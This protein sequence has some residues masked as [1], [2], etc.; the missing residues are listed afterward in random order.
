MSF[1]DIAT[2]TVKRNGYQI[3]FWPMTKNRDIDRIKNVDLS[4]KSGQS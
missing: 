1:D 4:K 2:V 3:N